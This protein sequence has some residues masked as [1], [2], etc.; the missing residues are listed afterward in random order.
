MV[1]L[2]M[3][4]RLVAA[5]TVRFCVFKLV[6]V[7]VVVVMDCPVMPDTPVMLEPVINILSPM[8]NSLI[9]L[10]SVVSTISGILFAIMHSLYCIFIRF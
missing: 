2:V 5:V 3:L 1:M 7:P 6:N 8:G 4:P 10:L 9:L